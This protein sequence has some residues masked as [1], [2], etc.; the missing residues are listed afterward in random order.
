MDKWV[1][2]RGPTPRDDDVFSF[3]ILG[4]VASDQDGLLLKVTHPE[5]SDLRVRP[6][7]SVVAEGDEEQH[8]LIPLPEQLLLDGFH[9]S[10]RVGGMLRGRNLQ[11]FCAVTRVLSDHVPLDQHRL[12]RA[13]KLVW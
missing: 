13:E 5:G 8:L 12:I 1:L 10:R 11:L 7:S 6:P 4:I 2:P 9:L 3:V